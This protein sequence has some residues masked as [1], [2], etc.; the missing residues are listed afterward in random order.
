MAAREAGKEL[1]YRDAGQLS[2]LLQAPVVGTWDPR[3]M[4]AARA[5]FAAPPPEPAPPRGRGQGIPDFSDDML[6]SQQRLER[7]IL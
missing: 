6:T 3:V 1:P 2:V 7:E 5:T 4:A